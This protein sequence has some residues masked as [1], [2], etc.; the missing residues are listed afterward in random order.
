MKDFPK[1][2]EWNKKVIEIDPQ[3]KEA[4]YVLG[5][6]AWTQFVPPDR[7]A[8]LSQSMKPED[9]GPLKD[10]KTKKDPTTK[11]DLKAKYW[12]SLTDGIEYEKKALAVD[13][14]YENAMAYM[15]LLIRYRADLD[16]SKE[17]YQ[18]DVK[19]ADGW[20]QKNLETTKK[21]AAKKAASAEQSN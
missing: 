19:E 9:P 18:T 20:V 21:K 8:R 15:N 17:Q 4:Y 14:D 5:V 2:Q 12:Q 13:P 1:A 16:D 6:I 3:N 11:A 7:E 10:P